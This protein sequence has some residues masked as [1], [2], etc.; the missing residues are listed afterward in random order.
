MQVDWR[1]YNHALIPDSEPHI[2]CTPP[3]N[4]RMFWKNRGGIHYLQGGQLILIVGMKQI[5]GM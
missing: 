5:G 2:D 1:Y 3:E 4:K